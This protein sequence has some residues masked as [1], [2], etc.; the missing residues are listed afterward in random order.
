M[1]YKQQLLKQTGAFTSST[2]KSQYKAPNK[3]YAPLSAV[4]Q[5]LRQDPGNL[6]PDERLQLESTIGT[7]A[8]QEISTGKRTEWVP[9][10]RGISAQLSTP[11]QAKSADGGL[12]LS[13]EKVDLEPKGGGRS[14]PKSIVDNY[15]NAGFP[16][17]AKGKLYVDDVAT[18][19]IQAKAYTMGNKTVVQSS[20]AN[21][22]N[23]LG[24]EMT[25]HV[26]QATKNVQPNISGTP[27]NNDPKMEREAD[28]NGR[29]VAQNR[30]VVL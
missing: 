9:E 18:K 17:A 16:E 11:I 1:S 12:T 25:H 30:R 29:R 6:S 10:F 27:I 24:H 15:T 21:D 22:L 8:M 7:T 26:H 5:R 20:A 13:E 4:V 2:A 3:T 19:S 28:E 23:V 14:F